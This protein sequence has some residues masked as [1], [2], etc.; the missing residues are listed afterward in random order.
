VSKGTA[1]NSG[2]TYLMPCTSWNVLPFRAV[3][4]LENIQK[5]VG[6]RPNKKKGNHLR[7]SFQKD[8][9]QASQQLLFHSYSYGTSIGFCPYHLWGT[10]MHKCHRCYTPTKKWF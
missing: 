1:F 3:F 8:N 5:S 9:T 6:A 10:Y 2:V 7:W 4:T